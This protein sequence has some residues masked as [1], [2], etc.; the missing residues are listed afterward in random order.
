LDERFQWVLGEGPEA[1]EAQPSPIPPGSDEDWLDAYSRAVITASDTVSPSVAHLTVTARS[2]GGRQVRR[3][4]QGTGSGFVITPDGFVLTNSHVVRNAARIEVTLLDD[5]RYQADMIGDDPDIDL[6]V[7]QVH[8]PDLVPVALGDSRALRVGQLV[9]A[10]GNP[11][12]F[13]STVTAGVISALGRSLRA[14]TGRLI[15]NVI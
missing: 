15:D 14:Q 6:A 8:A 1:E 12:A 4:G 7:V 2:K 9:I 5:R 10:I 13:Q 3:A 11:Y